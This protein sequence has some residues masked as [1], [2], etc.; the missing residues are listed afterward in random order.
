MN[1]YS[2]SRTKQMN[3]LVSMKPVFSFYELTVFFFRK[4]NS[5]NLRFLGKGVYVFILF[6]IGQIIYVCNVSI[7]PWIPWKPERIF[8]TVAFRLSNIG[9][10]S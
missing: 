4:R 10:H 1:K 8:T 5:L 3:E 2:Y 7:L 6:F 9:R